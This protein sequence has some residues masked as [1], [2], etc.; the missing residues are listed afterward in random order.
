MQ[1]KLTK[2]NNGSEAAKPALVG[3]VYIH[4]GECH[5]SKKLC[6]YQ[7][8]DYVWAKNIDQSLVHVL[9]ERFEKNEPI[10]DIVVTVTNHNGTEK[11]VNWSMLKPK[12]PTGDYQ[13]VKE[14]GIF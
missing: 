7:T 13:K 9:I 11:I 10:N 2:F 4:Q 5:P 14:F 6:I 1:F 3:E 8:K 12:V